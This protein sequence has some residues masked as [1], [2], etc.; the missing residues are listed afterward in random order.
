MAH[1]KLHFFIIG[2]PK[3]GTSSL[4]AWLNAHP[5]IFMPSEKEPNFFNTDDRQIIST[6]K[7]Y[8]D[9][10]RDAGDCCRV[11]GEATVWYLYSAEAVPN[12]LLYQPEARFIVMLR[13]PLEMAPALHMEMVL[14]GLENVSDFMEAW[15]LQEERRRGLRLPAPSWGS[16]RFLYGDICSLGAQCQRLLRLVPE[17]RVL[18]ILLDDIIASPRREYLRV[19]QFLGVDDDGR[20][21]FPILNKARIVRWQ[22]LHRI[23]FRL[24]EA[25]TQAKR[26]TGVKFR[27]GVFQWI[28]SAN[29]VERPRTPLTMK[30]EITLRDYFRSDV[31]LLGILLKRDLSG[32]LDG[33]SDAA[34]TDV[35]IDSPALGNRPVAGN[36]PK[37]K[38][39][40]R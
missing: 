1:R 38:V 29:I 30:A 4:A 28:S 5:N 23:Q 33:K 15:D 40:G 22:F 3:S 34:S 39:T 21:E 11:V 36:L 31:A 2:A 17:N 16:R 9:L 37:I 7:E 10:Y 32:W 12:I 13:N 35:V 18:P 20:V 19:L 25:I 26:R 14:S 24:T 6:V 27:L 8:E